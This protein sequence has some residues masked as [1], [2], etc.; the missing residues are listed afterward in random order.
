MKKFYFTMK[1]LLPMLLCIVALGTLNAQTRMGNNLLKNGEFDD[2]AAICPMDKNN[3]WTY[4]CAEYSWSNY[5]QTPQAKFETTAFE[6][7]SGV[8]G[9]KAYIE[10]GGE[11]MWHAQLLQKI[12][13]LDEGFYQANFTAQA[14]KNCVIKFYLQ[15]LS[16][17]KEIGGY[18]TPSA[19][20]VKLTTVAQNFTIYVS[21][22]D[23]NYT[24]P[25]KSMAFKIDIGNPNVDQLDTYNDLGIL[26]FEKDGAEIAIDNISFYKVD[27]M[28][29]TSFNETIGLEGFGVYPNPANDFINIKS[30]QSINR[31]EISDITGRL[32]KIIDGTNVCSRI[33]VG[34][35]P[36]GLYIIRAYGATKD[37]V[38]KFNRK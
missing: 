7:L 38:A 3:V 4:D 12:G 27:K 34:D 16:N 32:M 15:S 36:K 20:A 29:S 10:S 18:A 37:Y 30:S 33:N 28:P 5:L 8:N 6:G 23:T 9:F 2:A 13:N 19:Q 26:A 21:C 17:F 25:M 22:A 14:S 11:V 24:E 35:L 31:A 1:A